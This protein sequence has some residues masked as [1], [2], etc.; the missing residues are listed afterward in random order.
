MPRRIGTDEERRALMRPL[1]RSMRRSDVSGVEW[2]KR[3]GVGH[4]TLSRALRGE[5]SINVEQVAALSRA[6]DE[7]LLLVS[8]KPTLIQRIK[9]YLGLAPD[10][11]RVVD[12]LIDSIGDLEEPHA[13]AIRLLVRQLR[14]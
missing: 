9:R 11:R 8:E 14:R 7:E 6:I 4:S 1:G 2:G 10:R 3:S 13:E 5:R 12:E